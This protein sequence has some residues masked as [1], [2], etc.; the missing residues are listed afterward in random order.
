MSEAG[1]G[2]R[3]ALLEDGQLEALDAA[4][5]VGLAGLDETLARAELIDR[6]SV[7]A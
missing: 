7:V 4:V 2:G 1:E 3:P 6:L 5:R